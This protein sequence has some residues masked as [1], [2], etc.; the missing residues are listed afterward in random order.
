MNDILDI[1]LK[2]INHVQ[3]CN[4]RA[5]YGDVG[6]QIFHGK[7]Q[8]CLNLLKRQHN[9]L[10][11]GPYVT[12]LEAIIAIYTLTVYWLESRKFSSIP[13]L[14]LSYKHETKLPI[15]TLERLKEEYSLQGR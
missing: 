13:F 5:K 15:L 8:V 12:A 2:G 9:Y 6:R 11:D 10:D 7:L 1:M 4:I 3:S 14:S